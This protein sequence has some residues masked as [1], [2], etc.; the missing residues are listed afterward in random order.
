MRSLTV[1]S[2][3][4]K[5]EKRPIKVKKNEEERNRQ[6]KR[7]EKKSVA[8]DGKVVRSWLALSKVICYGLLFYVL[9]FFFDIHH[10]HFLL[11][12]LRTDAICVRARVCVCVRVSMC[13]R[14]DGTTRAALHHLPP[15]FVC[16]FFL[17]KHY[18]PNRIN[19]ELVSYSLF[20]SFVCFG[21][22]KLFIYLYV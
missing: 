2:E 1:I 21:Y 5:V 12:Y 3:T 14:C 22:M 19:T 20:T 16:V 6:K 13:V 8:H 15:D 18:I 17:P 4:N 7:G 10:H 11:L 9:L